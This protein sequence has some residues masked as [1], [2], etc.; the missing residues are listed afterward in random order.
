MNAT[1]DFTEV[2]ENLFES[3]LRCAKV[4]VSHEDT[5]VRIIVPIVV[6]ALLLGGRGRLVARR[7]HADGAASKVDAIELVNR[8]VGPFHSS[9][10]D[11]AEAPAAPGHAVRNVGRLL[12]LAGLSEELVE[13]FVCNVKVQVADE[14][15][16]GLHVV[17]APGRKGR[18]SVA[19]RREVEFLNIGGRF[20]GV[21]L[22]RSQHHGWRADRAAQRLGDKLPPGWKDKGRRGLEEKSNNSQPEHTGR[23]G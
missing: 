6:A 1:L 2:G 21:F 8:C 14:D 9:K 13:F 5:A 7:V 4:Q 15:L 18:C 22:I 12:H 16:P 11:K 10:C 23:H 20:R 3:L 19:H 17:T